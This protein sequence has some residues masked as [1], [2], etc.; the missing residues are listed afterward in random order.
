MRI[1]LFLGTLCLALAF[2]AC[3]DTPKDAPNAPTQHTHGDNPPPPNF[4]PD[5][6]TLPPPKHEAP[7][8]DKAHSCGMHGSHGDKEGHSCGMHGDKMDAHKHGTMDNSPSAQILRAM[9]EPIMRQ[10]PSNSNIAGIDFLRDMIPHH[11]GAI[12]SAR[13][14]LPHAKGNKALEKLAQNIIDSQTKEIADFHALLQS[15]KLDSTAL[16]EDKAREFTKKNRE[17]MG[18]MMKGMSVKPSGNASYDFILAMIA[19]HQGAVDVSKIVLD[20]SKDTAVR[21]IAQ[22]I[23]KA[24]EAEIAQMSEMIKGLKPVK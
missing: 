7:H 4:K 23:I 21:E 9:H 3:K 12:D 24:Q 11:Q 22:N 6:Q 13:L 20:Y 17:A 14:V 19:H 1:F 5:E 16:S 8:G 18:S 2:S 10:A 15:G